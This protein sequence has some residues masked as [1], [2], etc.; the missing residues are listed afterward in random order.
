[1]KKF[2]STFVA[3]GLLVS[4]ASAWASI[5]GEEHVELLGADRKNQKI[6]FVRHY[7]DERGLPPEVFSFDMRPGS[8]PVKVEIKHPEPVKEA[9][10][11]YIAEYEQRKSW[12]R[13]LKSELS[14]IDN[15]TTSGI[16]QLTVSTKL[17]GIGLKST[18][19]FIPVFRFKMTATVKSGQAYGNT[20]V[21]A[22]GSRDVKIKGWTKLPDS[23]LSL[24][25]ISYAGVL[26]PDEGT[27]EKEDFV[28][29]AEQ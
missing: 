2:F 1:M 24:V 23:K 3:F 16:D 7:V 22:Y 8:Q 10:D 11:R 6:Y 12:I 17:T 15:G 21:T 9:S 29:L 27:Y 4:V 18:S 14:A 25:L 5:G 13:R 20:S 28:V 19:F 26:N